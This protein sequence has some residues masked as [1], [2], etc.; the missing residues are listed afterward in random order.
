MQ[1][2]IEAP[3]RTFR[4]RRRTWDGAAWLQLSGELDIASSAW[5]AGSIRQAL[6]AHRVVVLDLEQ[7]EFV[8]CSGLHVIEDAA[9]EA[10]L[11]GRRLMA[12]RVPAAILRVFALTGANHALEHYDLAA[13]V[14]EM[15]R[16]RLVEGGA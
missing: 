7:L 14:S 16:L 8:D 1:L 6:A 2:S 3:T 11:A 13:G 15:P 5:L 10:L 9:V 4:C 12:A